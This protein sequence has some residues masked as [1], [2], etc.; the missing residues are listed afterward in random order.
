MPI[1]MSLGSLATAYALWTRRKRLVLAGAMSLGALIQVFVNYTVQFFEPDRRNI[2]A[3]VQ[4]KCSRHRP[5][6]S[7]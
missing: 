3:R 2:A 6:P 4:P 1:V 7:A 5:R